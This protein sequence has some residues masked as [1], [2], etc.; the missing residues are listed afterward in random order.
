MQTESD[1]SASQPSRKSVGASLLPGPP[2]SSTGQSAAEQEVWA[3]SATWAEANSSM[4]V[5]FQPAPPFTSPPICS[6]LRRPCSLGFGWLV[7]ALAITAPG[8]M[9]QANAGPAAATSDGA[10]GSEAPALTKMNNQHAKLHH[11]MPV[12]KQNGRR[13]Q[14]PSISPS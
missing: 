2:S 6:S 11:A 10:R 4:A 9:P 5:E 14:V 7:A 8:E 12:R 3:V 13:T 1:D